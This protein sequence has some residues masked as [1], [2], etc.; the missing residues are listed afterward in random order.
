MSTSSATVSRLA[1]RKKMRLGELLLGVPFDPIQAAP[2]LEQYLGYYWEGEGD[3]YRAIVLDGDGLALEILGKAVV[4][5]V[6]IGEDRWKLRPQP[7]TVLAFDRSPAGEVT[8]YHIGEHQEFRFEPA[9]DL[10][11]A[12]EVATRVAQA[13]R[14]DL[15]DRQVAAASDVGDPGVVAPPVDFLEPCEFIRRERRGAAEHRRMGSDRH[16]VDRDALPYAAPRHQPGVLTDPC[17]LLD[18]AVRSHAH[19]GAELRVD[20]R[21]TEAGGML[22]E[23]IRARALCWM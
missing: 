11:S 23:N 22:A 10:P 14:I 12:D 7:A 2:P 15:L 9:A 21:L 13:H 8:G 17:A 1:R 20:A 4:P 16:P 18:H 3:P 6:Y 5:L 19:A